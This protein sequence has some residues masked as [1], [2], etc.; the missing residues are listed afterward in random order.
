MFQGHYSLQKSVNWLGMGTDNLIKIKTD[1]YGRMIVQDLEQSIL[2]SREEGKVPFFVNAT[3]G[4]TVLGAVDPINELVNICDKYK[5][6]LHVDVI[7][8]QLFTASVYS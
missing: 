1:Q 5:L 3:A 8:L 2:K 7:N 6:W 4:T